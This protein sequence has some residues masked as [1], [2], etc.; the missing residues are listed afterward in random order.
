MLDVE[1]ELLDATGLKRDASSKEKYLATLA[2]QAH[3][4]PDTVWAKLSAPAQNWV[5]SCLAA[6]R[7][8]LFSNRIPEF[9]TEDNPLID[10]GEKRKGRIKAKPGTSD[11]F[12]EIVIDNP[13]M[14]IIAVMELSKKKG[15]EIPEASASTV[16]YQTHSTL[17]MLHKKGLLGD[18]K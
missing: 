9:P 1:Q 15:F 13:G 5:W 11:I 14:D 12:R 8:S 4:L 10:Y 3:G 7:G 6:T 17:K 2:R 16:F 18:K